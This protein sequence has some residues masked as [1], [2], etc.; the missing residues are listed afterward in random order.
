MIKIFGFGTLVHE[1]SALNTCPNLQNFKTSRTQ[2]VCRVFG[3]VNLRA[4]F[5]GDVHWDSLEVAS[6]FME[7]REGQD[8]IGVT[9]DV[10]KEE[11]PAM[12][13]R[14]IDYRCREVS[15][16]TLDGKESGTALTFFGFRNDAEFMAN[17][18]DEDKIYI[19]EQRQGY[20]GNIYRTDVY[21]ARSYLEK[22]YRAYRAAGRA[23]YE[24]FLDSSYLADRKTL[25]V[26]YLLSKGADIRFDAPHEELTGGF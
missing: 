14:E 15:Y 23:A 10:P 25:L 19:D 22:C 9:F 12:R 5:R 16:E 20:T 7:P 2:N 1:E 26:D 4:A 8:I 11:W 21:P 17:K 24:N 13:L 18:S 3:K 6:C